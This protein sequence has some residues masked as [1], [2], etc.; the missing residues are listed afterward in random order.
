MYCFRKFCLIEDNLAYVWNEHDFCNAI[1]FSNPEYQR[2]IEFLSMQQIEQIFPGK[3]YFAA[4]TGT[5]TVL[6]WGLAIEEE[7]TLLE[8]DNVTLIRCAGR[9]LV[10]IKLSGEVV[11]WQ[12]YYNVKRTPI[13]I[14]DIVVDVQANESLHYVALTQRGKVFEWRGRP[15]DT[16]LY[17]EP[18]EIVL[19]I[20]SPAVGIAYPISCSNGVHIRT[21]ILITTDAN[22]VYKGETGGFC[23]DCEIL[24]WDSLKGFL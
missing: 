11:C 15:K 21:H 14:P 24:L 17:S 10:V 19:P 12:M 13:K 9:T 2:E 3:G 16:I 6:C 8:E 22:K 23:V 18:V 20:D 1:H 5:G 7:F 4:L